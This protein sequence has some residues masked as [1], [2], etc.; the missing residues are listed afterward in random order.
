MSLIMDVL[1]WRPDGLAVFIILV[2]TLAAFSVYEF[3]RAYK[4]Y[5]EIKAMEAGK[6]E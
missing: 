2:V 3:R 6:K 1:N 5:K 4:T